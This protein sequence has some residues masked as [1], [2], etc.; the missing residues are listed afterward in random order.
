MFIR[1]RAPPLLGTPGPS[2]VGAGEAGDEAGAVPGAV[3]PGQVAIPAHHSSAAAQ[4]PSTFLP[5]VIKNLE[6]MRSEEGLAGDK[7]AQYGK[8]NEGD[9][10]AIAVDRH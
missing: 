9:K 2:A 4:A 6:R 8:A 1:V 3:A 5:A 7:I 10:G